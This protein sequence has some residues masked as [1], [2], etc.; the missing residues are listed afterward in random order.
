MA[1]PLRKM[2]LAAAIYVTGDV[3]IKTA[4]FFLLP[5]MTRFLSPEDYGILASVTAFVAVLSLLLQLNM[6][7]ALMRFYPEASDESTRQELLGTLILF[8]VGWSLFAVLIINFAGGGLLDNIY[9]GVRFEPYL[10]LATWIAFANGL[11]TLPLCL[12]QMQQR[13][14]MHRVLS[15]T[16]F[17][18]NTLFMLLFVVGMRMGAFGGVI[19]QLAGAI[20]AS[21]PFMFLLRRHMR[22]VLNTALLKTCLV[23]SLP[24]AGYALGGWIMDMS[25]RVFIER[26]VNL[27]ELGLFNVGNQFS[28]ILGFVLGASGLA[29]TP[30]FYETVKVEEGPRLLARF[31]V[32][33]VAVTAGIGLS[34]AVLSREAL[35]ILT[36]PRYHT[37]YRVI[38]LL[39]A[40]Q[41]MT[42]FWHLVVNPLMLRRKTMYLTILMVLSAALSVCL[43]LYLIPRYG[44]VGAAA[45]PL[46]ANVFLNAAVFLFSIRLYPVPYNYVHFALVVAFALL[47]FAAA[48]TVTA[49]NP[50]VSFGIRTVILGLYPALLLVFGVIKISDLRR[51]VESL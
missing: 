21:V 29:F 43:N 33:Y 51:L 26:F 32:I 14:V 2:P 24:L 13:P 18:F 36:Q 8:S 39:T 10:R 25:N 31:G 17:L 30:I 48:G 45:S 44:I 20:G 11:T 5:V 3:L 34:I 42:S 38:P 28:M 27:S 47:I 16:T 37:A 35:Q 15:L 7:G 12:L 46:V 19:G 22:V 40:T 6:N 4:G 41:T 9:K 49:G 23:F 1:N 50:F